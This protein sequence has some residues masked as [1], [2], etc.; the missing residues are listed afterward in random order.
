MKSCAA[1]QKKSSA[2]DGVRTRAGDPSG[3][4]VHRL[5][6]SATAATEYPQAVFILKI[7]TFL[8]YH[9]V[10][11]KHHGHVGLGPC[12]HRSSTC[13]TSTAVDPI[14]DANVVRSLPNG[15]GVM[16]E[17]T[18]ACVQPLQGANPSVIHTSIQNTAMRRRTRHSLVSINENMWAA[19]V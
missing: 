3:F 11:C 5:N 12:A 15:C 9:N 17:G 6:H 7:I 10:E 16:I 4:Q 2:A 1:E 14:M 19:C 8:P 13:K 18:F